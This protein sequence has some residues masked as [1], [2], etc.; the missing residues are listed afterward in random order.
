M[1]INE[2]NNSSYSVQSNKLAINF[3]KNYPVKA[4][5][6]SIYLRNKKLKS[7]LGDDVELHLDMLYEILN[8]QSATIENKIKNI[9]ELEKKISKEE[10][11][12]KELI[13][14]Y[15]ATNVAKKSLE[16][17][18]ENAKKWL[19]LYP[20]RHA[21]NLKQKVNR[22]DWGDIAGADVAGAIGTAAS[23]WAVNAV[24]GAGQVAYGSAIVGGAAL[25]S[26]CE[27]VGQLVSGWFD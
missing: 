18:S 21:G 6:R 20:K 3:I 9:T 11:T 4:D 15:S 22:Y 12:K 17:W 2:V 24:P 25:A 10:Y 7:K 13:L 16:Y 26:G 1:L 27:M 19:E 14:M 5:K 8:D 23:T